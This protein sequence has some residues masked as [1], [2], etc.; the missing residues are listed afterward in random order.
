MEI[1]VVQMAATWVVQR[2][3]ASAYRRITGNAEPTA[4]DADVPLGRIFVWA[5]TTAAAVAI[6][7]VAV[8][9]WVLR[10]RGAGVGPLPEFP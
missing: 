2:A 7:N 5:A 6:V 4:R 3:L 10:P 9:R 1:A 8:D